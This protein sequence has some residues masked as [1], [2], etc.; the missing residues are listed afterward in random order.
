MKANSVYF[1]LFL[2]SFINSAHAQKVTNDSLIRAIKSSVHDSTKVKALNK[3]AIRYYYN[4][5]DSAILLGQQ[6]AKLAEKRGDQS[7][8]QFALNNIGLGYMTKAN[9]DSALY[10]S[11]EALKISRAIKQ[12]KGI[13]SAYNN[14]GSIYCMKGEYD[15]AIKNFLLSLRISESIGDFGNA[16]SSYNNMALVYRNLNNTTQA[17]AYFRKAYGLYIKANDKRNVISAAMNIGL[18]N[19][20]RNKLDTAEKYFNGVLTN[21]DAVGD[22]LLLGT[23][24]GNLGYIYYRKNE[25][26]KSENFYEKALSIYQEVDNKANVALTH[27]AFAQLFIK[28]GNGIKARENAV[29][30]LEIA[31][32]SQSLLQVMDAHMIISQSDSVLGDYKSAYEAHKLYAL[33]RDSVI[34][35]DSQR[36][37]NE[38][39]AKY[40]SQKKDLELIKKEA[41]LGKQKL[42]RN[43]LIIGL[44]L[45]LALIFIVFRGFTQKQKTNKII[46]GQK[47]EVELKNKEI[48]DSISYAQRIQSALLIPEKELAKS[49]NDCFIL[50]MPKDIVSGDFYWFG[51]SKTNKI[52]AVADCTGHGVPGGFMSMLGYEMLQEILLLENVET[53]SAALNILNKKVTDTLNKNKRVYRDGM[54]MA[55]C[56]FNME[57]QQLQFS[58]ANR[59]VIMIRNNKLTELKPDKQTIGGNIDGDLIPFNHFE[60]KIQKGDLFYLFSDGYADQFGGPAG[61]KFMYKRFKELLSDNAEK[62][63][64]EQKEIIHAEFAQWKGNSEQIDDVCIIGIKI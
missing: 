60:I 6:C 51:E 37:I 29:K 43:G 7:A 18:V 5:P 58:G 14:I 28:Q 59:P 39:Q 2:F 16:A 47:K 11:L 13:M 24:Y 26:K 27:I 25:Y 44:A 40:E 3:L 46:S 54:D 19:I 55:L 30:S 53:T 64:T 62:N 56:A 38:M 57:K 61:K 9:F 45:A 41:E 35:S 50:Y 8:L 12:N 49:F 1:F 20:D 34:N 10:F 42:T 17:E 15:E 63:L 36:S 33:T 52:I 31:E 23:A 32:E 22:L 4:H 48:L 21:S